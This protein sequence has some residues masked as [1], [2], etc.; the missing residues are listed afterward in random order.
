MHRGWNG[1]ELGGMAGAL[2]NLGNAVLD[3][4]HLEAA[5][6]KYEEAHAIYYASLYGDDHQRVAAVL[7]IM[8][9]LLKKRGEGAE[10]LRM[11]VAAA[12]ATSM[13]VL[14]IVSLD[15]MKRVHNPFKVGR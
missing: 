12:R 7:A 1:G 13:R 6:A 8:A 5:M 14:W 2:A 15:P 11:A 4:G 10:G 3:N 9:F